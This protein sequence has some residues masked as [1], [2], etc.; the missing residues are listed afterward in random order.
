MKFIAVVA[1]AAFCTLSAVPSYGGETMDKIVQRGQL[2]ACV[3]VTNFPQAYLDPSGKPIGSQI[4]LLEDIAKRLG[5]KAGKP[6]KMEVVVTNGSNRIPFLQN[7]QCDLIFANLAPTEERKKLVR[8]VE[9]YWYAAGPDLV[10]LESV[11]IESWEELRG[12]RVCGYQ[13]S[14]FN[15]QA[16]ESFGIEVL[17]FV[18]HQEGIQAMRDGRCIGYL[19]VDSYFQGQLLTEGDGA[20]KGIIRQKLEPFDPGLNALFI[21]YGDE[22]FATFMSDTVTDWHTK[23]VVIDTQKKWGLEPPAYSYEMQKK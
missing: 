1:S 5:E 13:G 15:I 12:K 6:V 14:S 8:A 23:G 3:G 20:W 17:A 11:K 21:R 16:S 10:T 19:N 4:D 7:G 9:P 18:A 2:D 22:K